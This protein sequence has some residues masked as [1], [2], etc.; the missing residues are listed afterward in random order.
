MCRGR[1]ID[2]VDCAGSDR[3]RPGYPSNPCHGYGFC[4][5]SELPTRTRT[6]DYPS[7]QPVRVCKP[8][9][10]PT[11]MRSVGAKSAKVL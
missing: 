3:Q 4:W 1:I 8:V 11:Q 7:R 10:F 6:R 9:T 5:G 2:V